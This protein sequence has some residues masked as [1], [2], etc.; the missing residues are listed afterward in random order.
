MG[1]I[2]AIPVLVGLLMVQIG[3]L[4]N[5]PLLYG[6]SDLVLLAIIAWSLQEPVRDAW[7]WGVIGGLLMTIT[8][9]IPL[10]VYLIA[11]LMV[12]GAASVLRRVVWRIPF[13][14][15]LVVTLIGT[16]ITLGLSY[17]SLQIFG[18]SFSLTSSLQLIIIPSA[19]F[20]LLFALPVYSMVSE[21][22]KWV[23]PQVLEV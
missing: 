17:V 10:G 20:N 18:I 4:N 16:F 8:S 21:I 1:T 7:R 9:A 23:Y 15:M 11:Y 6:Y 22:A 2:L 3:V 14:A 19:I 13:I 12:V 5:L